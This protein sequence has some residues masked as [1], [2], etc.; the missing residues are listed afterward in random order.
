MMIVG[1]YR[2]IMVDTWWFWVS[3]EWYWVI[4]DGTGSVDGGNGWYLAV[5]A[6]HGAHLSRHV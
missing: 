3:K 4:Y 2:A 1:Q 5:L 6:Q